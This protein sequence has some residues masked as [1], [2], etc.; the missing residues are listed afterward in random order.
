MK[1]LGNLIFDDSTNQQLRTYFYNCD[2]NGTITFP[3]SAATGTTGTAI[4]FDGCSFSGASAI[5]IPNQTLYTIFFTRCAFIGQT[6][7]NNQAQANATKIVFTDCSYLPTLTTLGF[8]VLNGL[9]TT[10]TTTQANFGSIVLGGTT[11]QLLLGNGSTIPTTTY[12]TMVS[13]TFTATFGTVSNAIFTYS[14]IF[15]GT[16][17]IV[18]LGVPHIRSTITGGPFFTFSATTN[19]LPAIIRP[20]FTECVLSMRL[21]ENNTFIYGSLMLYS[22]GAIGF[23]KLSQWTN[24]TNQNGSGCSNPGDYIYVTYVV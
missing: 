18:T 6:I 15:N 5:V 19:A 17:K 2:W 21:L 8:C 14:Y 12:T 3:T 9:N 23:H 13:S 10:L 24:N 20:T 16:T 22:T 4:Y 1:F 7:T 11:S